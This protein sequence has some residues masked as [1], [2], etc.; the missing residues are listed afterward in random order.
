M[1][2]V[3]KCFQTC[4]LGRDEI[5]MICEQIVETA[6]SDVNPKLRA[7]LKRVIFQDKS[8]KTLKKEHELLKNF[9]MK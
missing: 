1:L 9:D 6:S 7:K 5:K 3:S 8:N 2:N 4:E